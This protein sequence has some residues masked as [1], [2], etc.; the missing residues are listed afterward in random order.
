MSQQHKYPL[1]IAFETTI[2]NVAEWGKYGW[3]PGGGKVTHT[4]EDNNIDHTQAYVDELS[5]SLKDLIG[6]HTVK[7]YESMNGDTVYSFNKNDGV[8]KFYK[9]ND[10]V[11][12]HIVYELTWELYSTIIT[13]R[14]DKTASKIKIL[15]KQSKTSKEKKLLIITDAIKFQTF[16]NWIYGMFSYF[17]KLENELVKKPAAKPE[18]PTISANIFNQDSSPKRQAID[19]SVEETNK[20]NNP[21]KETLESVMTKEGFSQDIIQIIVDQEIDLVTFDDYDTQSLKQDLK[22]VGIKLGPLNKI[23]KFHESRKS[24]L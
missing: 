9:I 15:E 3:Q 21:M 2:S 22:D 13:I 1:Q 8:F 19:S 16:H 6:K 5:S 14:W 7:N 4:V 10:F 17:Y 18:P 20:V 23:I 12:H 24:K 11:K